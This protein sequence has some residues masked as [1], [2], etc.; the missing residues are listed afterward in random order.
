MSVDAEACHAAEHVTI[1]PYESD[2]AP[3]RTSLVRLPDSLHLPLFHL[4]RSI[5]YAA[6]HRAQHRGS[7]HNSVTQIERPNRTWKQESTRIQVEGV[8][9]CL[10]KLT[11]GCAQHSQPPAILPCKPE[12]SATQQTCTAWKIPQATV[13][14]QAA[15][16]SLIPDSSTDYRARVP[17]AVSTAQPSQVRLCHQS[18][19][20]GLL[21]PLLL[22]QRL[23]WQ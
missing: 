19:A 5:K 20:F 9:A 11:R 22:L 21:L 1:S 17:S 7:V 13:G 12:D 15:L 4:Q 18:I 16:S 3:A 10:Y 8:C 2:L 23:V 14:L 6:P